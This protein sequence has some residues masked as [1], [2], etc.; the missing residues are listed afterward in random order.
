MK[1]FNGAVI[2]LGNIGFLLGIDPLRQG[3]WSHVAAYQQ[4]PHTRLS[5]AVEID[6][7]KVSIFKRHH[8]DIPVFATVRG[9]M[10]NVPVDIVS[11]CT[12]AAL[13]YTVLKELIDYP[14][15]AIFCEKPI[16]QNLDDA[17]RI[18]DCCAQR[19]IALAVHHNRRWQKS[20]LTVKEAI[21][22]G[23]IGVV[24]AVNAVYS[25]QVFN[26]GTHLV[27]TVR[28]LVQSEAETVS[29]IFTR[30]DSSDP[31]I[32]GWIRFGRGIYC[33]LTVSGK[34]EDLI[35]EIDVIGSEG[36]IRITENGSRV[37]SSVFRPSGRYSG[38]RE[39]V[40]AG[41]MPEPQ[42]NKDWLVNAVTNIVFALEDGHKIACSGRDGLAAF[43]LSLALLESARKQGMPV[44]VKYVSGLSVLSR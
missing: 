23:G 25:G 8:Q 20:Y 17:R 37:E 41:V 24:R 7:Q 12:P 33:A 22:K 39:L 21:E 34:R 44:E 13:H 2:G 27:D 38:Y 5:G 16:A 31:D 1:V 29:G 40:S 15:K 43:G 19:Q 6:A 32:S 3:A 18:L 30:E 42:E 14:L 28:M 35:F 10:D 4:C 11:I 26:I 36:R 9:L